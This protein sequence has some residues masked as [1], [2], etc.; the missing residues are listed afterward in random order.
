MA[1]EGKQVDPD[2]PVDDRIAAAI[3]SRLE[4]GNLPCAAAF[5][6]AE[7][8]GVPPAAVGLAADRLRIH[9]ARCQLGL[10]RYPERGKGW[11]RASVDALPAP[12]GLEAAL[13]A[14]GHERGEISCDQL[15]QEAR[16]F[17]APRL[18]VGWLA[19]RLG[20]K[21]RDCPLGAF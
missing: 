14:A 19:D 2:V 8:L 13:A 7:A 15:W 6:L 12:D 21:I 3:R 20:L 5:E 17:G 16:R 4:E 18:Q 1:L 9:L 10:F 11:E